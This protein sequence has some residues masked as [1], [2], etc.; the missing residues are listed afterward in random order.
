MDRLQSMEAFVKVV[1]A[2]SFAAAADG[3]GLSRAMVSKHVGALED[4]LGA[5]LLQ[6]TTRRLNLTEAGRAYFERAREVLAQIA[7][8]EDLT[9]ALQTAPRGTLRLNCSTGFGVRHLSPALAIF[10][11]QYPDL[12][13]DLTL[14]DRIVDLVEDGFDLVIRIGILQDSALIARRLAP[15]RL[16]LCAAPAYIAARGEPAHP[17][18]LRRHNWL[19]YAYSSVGD[20]VHLTGPDGTKMVVPAT[21]NFVSNNGDALRAAAIAGQGIVLLPTFAIGADLAEGSLRVV[22]P[23]WK[24]PELTIHAVYPVNR[25]LAA[26]VRLFVDFLAER[27]R[28]DPPWDACWLPEHRKEGRR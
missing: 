13:V 19:S 1:E 6:R 15:A 12:R 18:D 5:R 14:S 11:A 7:E 2:G 16:V 10:Q 21:G 22:L 17:D 24:M 8:A 4:R 9:A 23:D 26:K 3:L 25:H 28:G 20:D 27:F